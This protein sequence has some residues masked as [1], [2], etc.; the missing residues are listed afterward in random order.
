M[1]F[2]VD[3]RRQAIMQHLMFKAMFE[4]AN[5]RADFISI[6]FAKPRPAGIDTQHVDPEPLGSVPHGEDGLGAR[7]ARTT[8]ASW[9]G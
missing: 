3:I 5:D 4:L 1:A 8:R 2:I 9:S 6:L 7:G